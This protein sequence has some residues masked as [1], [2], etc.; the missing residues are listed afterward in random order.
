MAKVTYK[1]VETNAQ[2]DGIPVL[3]GQLIYSKQ[4]K[5]YMDYGTERVPINGTTDTEMSGS[6]TNPVENWVIKDYVD[7]RILTLANNIHNG[8]ILW[9]NLDPSV[10]FGEQS[11]TLSSDNYDILLIL[12]RRTASQNILTPPI[13]MLK[14]MG[15]LPMGVSPSGIIMRRG[16]TYVNGTT[17]QFGTGTEGVD[18]TNNDLLIPMYIIGYNTGIFG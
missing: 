7:N 5:T 16:I 9:E 8:T 3:D 4:G 6:S 15:G 18:T 2:V 10:T 1:R 11:V 14:G 17:L 13:F 12:F